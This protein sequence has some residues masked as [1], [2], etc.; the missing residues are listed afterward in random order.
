MGVSGLASAG[1]AETF[2]PQRAF[3]MI[4]VSSFFSHLPERRF[5]AWLARLY[6]FLEPG[7]VLLLS[8]H[9]A[10]LLAEGGVDWSRG[11]VFRPESESATLPRRDYGTAW[12]T[13]QFVRE[14]V[15]R[16]CAGAQVSSVPFG[17]CAHQDLYVIVR[18]PAARLPPLEIGRFPRGYLEQFTFDRDTIRLAGVAVGATEEA[19]PLVQ[20]WCGQELVE[21]ST[22]AGTRGGSRAWDFRLPRSCVSPDDVIRVEAVSEKGLANILEMGTL[23]PHLEGRV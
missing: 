21:S 9:G 1:D 8:V 19:P 13:D 7:G 18:E 14:S 10:S 2:Q 20:L 3:G 16:E 11:I 6:G 23:R 17:F 5:G 4:V 12:V 15:M 22:V